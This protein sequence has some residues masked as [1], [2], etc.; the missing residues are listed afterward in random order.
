MAGK[1]RSRGF[2]LYHPCRLTAADPFGVTARNAAYRILVT[3]I[4]GS[5]GVGFFGQGWSSGR[6]KTGSSGNPENG[7]K[8]PFLDPCGAK[9][10]GSGGAPP[11]TLILL[12]NQRAPARRAARA[13]GPPPSGPC[14]ALSVTKPRTKFEFWVGVVCFEVSEEG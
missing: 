12:R 10:R 5:R 7:Q 9:P 3:R 8:W 2:V 13:V 1:V 4:R 11:T 6:P 14:L